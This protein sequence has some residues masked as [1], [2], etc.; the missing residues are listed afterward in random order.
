[1]GTSSLLV[2]LFS[3]CLAIQSVAGQCGGAGNGCFPNGALVDCGYVGITQAQCQANGCCWSPV[4]PNPYNLP[5][6]FCQN[7]APASWTPPPG[8]A[9]FN[10]TE[11][12]LMMSYFMLNIDVSEMVSSPCQ[13]EFSST[14]GFGGVVA[15]P[16][17]DTGPGGSYVYAWMRDSA[18]SMRTLMQT[19]NNTALVEAKMKKYV[20]WVLANQV[21]PDPNGIDVRVEPKF[22][23]PTPGVVFPGSWCRPQ[24][25]GPGLRAATLTLFANYLLDNGQKDY[26]LQ[27][28]WTG[29]QS[30][31]NGGAIK[32][33]LDWVVP[34]WPSNGCDLWEEVEST[35]FF[36]NRYNFRYALTLGSKLAS[37][38]GDS[39]SA[40]SYSQ[41]AAN[42]QP[43][44]LN[45][46]NGQFV[47]EST[48]RQED[49]AVLLAFNTGYLND[50]FFAPSSSY[51]AGTIS[52]LFNLFNDEY[53]INKLDNQTG[54]PGVL[55]GRYQGDSYDGGGPWILTTC[56]LAHLYYNA[57]N[58]ALVRLRD[59][60][61]E[62]AMVHWTRII[63]RRPKDVIDFASAVVSLGDGVLYRVRYH[64][65][66]YN[67][68]LS[69]QLNG[70][71]GQELSATDLTWSYAELFKAMLARET[72]QTNIHNFKL[73]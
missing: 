69:E 15:A 70:A 37:T 25:D 9:P 23:L 48:N 34:N 73:K 51:V 47:Y 66:P 21:A 64:V 12:D 2:I 32:F 58:D 40:A 61:D 26:V 10:S 6:C 16:D 3:C 57:A 1:M 17:C 35:D 60:P 22:M 8:G 67:F 38:M 30:R 62:E 42:I 44:C 5:Y 33:D 29:N 18:L 50:D 56:A 31:Y 13:A 71:T 4:S 39:A 28:L 46:W 20:Q 27:Y 7:S 59:M 55:L 11:M 36:W 52:V 63:G 14:A 45:H 65:A 53:Y 68:H 54:V 72:A 41:A 19:N 24:T 49:T 43:T